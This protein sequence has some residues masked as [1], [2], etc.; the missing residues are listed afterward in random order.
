MPN[1]LLQLGSKNFNVKVPGLSKKSKAHLHDVT[2][3]L[4]DIP[5]YSL[6][7]AGNPRRVPLLEP[8]LRAFGLSL[9][10]VASFRDLPPNPIVPWTPQT[11]SWMN[12]AVNFVSVEDLLH[13]LAEATLEVHGGRPLLCRPAASP[14]ENPRPPSKGNSFAVVTQMDQPPLSISH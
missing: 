6:C 7:F 11:Q 3:G 2:V 1:I 13:F 8:P 5:V 4:V 9:A 12:P 10:T 14:F